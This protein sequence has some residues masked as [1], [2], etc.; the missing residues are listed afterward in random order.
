MYCTECIVQA[1]KQGSNPWIQN[2]NKG[3]QYH[4]ISEDFFQTQVPKKT[5]PLVPVFSFNLVAKFNGSLGYSCTARDK[6]LEEANR[7]YNP[8][9]S[10]FASVILTLSFCLS[11]CFWVAAQLRNTSSRFHLYTALE[12][13]RVPLSALDCDWLILWTVFSKRTTIRSY[14]GGLISLFVKFTWQQMDLPDPYFISCVCFPWERSRVTGLC[15][16]ITQLCDSG[17]GWCL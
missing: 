6:C 3:L 14:P 5:K 16:P 10:P 17:N 12:F 1:I 8:V 15:Q 11:L 7:L 4:K 13:P 2:W 9:P